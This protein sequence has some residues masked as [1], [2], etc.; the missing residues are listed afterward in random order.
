LYN[1]FH[2]SYFSHLILLGRLVKGDEMGGACR[3]YRERDMHWGVGGETPRKDATLN[4][5]ARMAGL[6]F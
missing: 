3:M 5:W 1:E 6:T 2:D 4:T